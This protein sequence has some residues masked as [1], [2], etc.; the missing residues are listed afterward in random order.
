MVSSSTLHLRSGSTIFLTFNSAL[1]WF[2]SPLSIITVSLESQS[3]SH[4]Y[5]VT[6]CNRFPLSSRY[7][8][9][10]LR[11][12]PTRYCVVL[13]LLLAHHSSQ[14]ILERISALRYFNSSLALCATCRMISRCLRFPRQSLLIISPKS[15]QRRIFVERVHQIYSSHI[16]IQTSASRVYWDLTGWPV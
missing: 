6:S 14:P 13:I 11:P 2:E 5:I 8:E 4:H 10:Q 16:I 7:S 15:R 12:S 3:S 1:F 9:W